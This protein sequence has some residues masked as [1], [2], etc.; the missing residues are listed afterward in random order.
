MQSGNQGDCLPPPPPPLHP[1]LE[2]SP[3][4]IYGLTISPFTQ[5]YL[6][7]L[8]LEINFVKSHTL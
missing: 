3:S 6:F 5:K 7:M 4:A 2:S 8:M 1:V